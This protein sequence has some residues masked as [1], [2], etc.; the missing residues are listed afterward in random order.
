MI[1]FVASSSIH[2]IIL[3]TSPRINSKYNFL[4]KIFIQSYMFS[5]K[6]YKFDIIIIEDE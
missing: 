5:R 3:S 6:Y 1:Y 4:G 2:N